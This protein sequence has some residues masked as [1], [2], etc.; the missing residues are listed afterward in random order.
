MK[1]FRT[2][3]VIVTFAACAVAPATAQAFVDVELDGGR[4]LIGESYS[5][6]GEK[7]VVY[8]PS[9]N[10]EFDRASVRSIH[11]REGVMP[12]DVP[13]LDVPS[14]PGSS[15][16][17]S[18]APTGAPSAR[19]TDPAAH[20]EALAHRLIDLR[21]NRLAAK[22]RGDDQTQQKLDKEIGTLQTERTDNWKKLH[23]GDGSD[24]DR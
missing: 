12:I 17:P 24:E 7:I 19:S 22:Q 5:A 9:G 4:H 21:L 6:D 11:E 1:R 16:P 3:P 2:F 20:D 18:G 13:K 14:A 15:Q 8:R 10:L 23:P